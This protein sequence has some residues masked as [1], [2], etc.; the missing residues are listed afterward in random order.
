MNEEKTAKPGAMKLKACGAPFGAHS[1]RLL[2][3]GQWNNQAPD[4][5]GGGVLDQYAQRGD[6]GPGLHVFVEEQ[7]GLEKRV[8]LLLRHLKIERFAEIG[9]KICSINLG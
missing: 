3:L 5:G 4:F 1:A 7:A 9:T 2:Y 8:V 6:A